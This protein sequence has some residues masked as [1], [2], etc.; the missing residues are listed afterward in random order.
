MTLWEVRVI[1]DREV[2]LHFVS[3]ETWEPSAQVIE[4][5]KRDS[6]LMVNRVRKYPVISS[7]SELAVLTSHF[8][9]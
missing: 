1:D 2:L 5:F 7:D 9:W 4:T 8:G 3:D 6:G